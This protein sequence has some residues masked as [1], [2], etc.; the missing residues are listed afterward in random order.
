MYGAGVAGLFRALKNAFDPNGLLNPGVK[1]SRVSSRESRVS[2]SPISQ[3]KVGASAA[4]LPDDIAATLREIE[5]TGAWDT[6]RLIV[7]G[8][9]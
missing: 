3:L 4:Q 1:V 7:A 8:P 6:D 5:R 2:A 9:P